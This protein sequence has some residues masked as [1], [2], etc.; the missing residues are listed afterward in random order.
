MKSIDIWH[1]PFRGLK[2]ISSSTLD[3]DEKTKASRFHKE[4]DRQRYIYAHVYLRKVLSH[5]F[6]SVKE[7]EWE[8]EC[9]AFGKPEISSKHNCKL[10]FNLSHSHSHIYIICADTPCG[11][12]VE[13]IKDIEFSVELL[14]LVLSE[15]EQIEFKNSKHKDSL[16]FKYWTLKEAYVKAKGK[17][18]S[19]ALN[20]VIFKSLEDRETSFIMGK[21]LYSSKLFEDGYYLSFTVLDVQ[22]NTS[23]N[24]YKE[25]DL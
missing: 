1:M 17:G 15:D 7:E 23:I 3:I 24:F 21:D 8:F 12:D 16:F 13:E 20:S 18:V 19:M 2:K 22:E 25:E 10:H 11:I 4:E 9:N 5:Y 14:S 6:S